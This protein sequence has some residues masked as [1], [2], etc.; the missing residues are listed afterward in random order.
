MK[1][2]NFWVTLFMVWCLGTFAQ[3]QTHTDC[4]AP[5][6]S[7]I[8]VNVGLVDNT[9]ATP[10]PFVSGT[11]V[12][13][14]LATTDSIVRSILF[15]E[16][17][18]FSV[19]SCDVA[20]NNDTRLVLL[21]A[22]DGDCSRL[23]LVASSDNDCG[24]SAF[25]NDVKVDADSSYILVW[26]N[27]SGAALDFDWHYE[28]VD[29]T[30]Y[31]NNRPAT[32]GICNAA[33]LGMD[34]DSADQSNEY[35]SIEVLKDEFLVATRS[36]NAN[37]WYGWQV[38]TNVAN[39][40]WYKFVA[41][42][43]GAAEI[44]VETNEFNVQFNLFASNGY[45][46]TSDVT[47]LSLMRSIDK[48]DAAGNEVHREYC[49]TPG[50]VYYIQVD[51]FGIESG[52]FDILV[53]ELNLWRDLEIV[54]DIDTLDNV[55][56]CDDNEYYEVSFELVNANGDSLK[57]LADMMHADFDDTVY[58]Y[59]K[60]LKIQ[61]AKDAA[62][63][64]SYTGTTSY[65]STFGL[66]SY[67]FSITDTCGNV[68]TKS[69]VLE[70]DTSV[71]PLTTAL[72]V[73]NDPFCVGTNSGRVRLN[74]SGGYQWI[75]RFERENGVTMG[76]GDFPGNNYYQIVYRYNSD[77]DAA[78]NTTIGGMPFPYDV[79]V[80]DTTELHTLDAGTYSLFVIDACQQATEVTVDTFRLR[81]PDFAVVEAH[82]VEEVDP[83]CPESNTGIMEVRATGGQG[84]PLRYNWYQAYNGGVA[85]EVGDDTTGASWWMLHA[86]TV[87]RLE[88]ES[89]GVYRVIVDDRCANSPSINQDTAWFNLEDP[90]NDTLEVTLTTTAP[91][92]Y[93][94]ADGTAN[95]TIVGGN[96]M[97]YIIRWWVDGYAYPAW[98][99]VPNP[100]NIPQGK[101]SISVQDR[102]DTLSMINIYNWD[103]TYHN[104]APIPNNDVCNAIAITE[105]DTL[106]TYT[107]RGAT[108]Q[109]GEENL[110]IPQ[111]IGDNSFNGWDEN[112]IDKSVWFSFVAPNSG[113]VAIDVWHCK[114][115]NNELNFDPQ[116]AVFS[117]DCNDLNS[118]SL[119]G[120]ND[121]GYNR[122]GNVINDPRLELFCLNPGQTYYVLVDG[123][124]DNGSIGSEEGV[125]TIAIENVDIEAINFNLNLIEAQCNA[126][127]RATFNGN[128]VGGVYLNHPNLQD[129]EYLYTVSVDGPDRDTT[130]E[131]VTANGTN[132][133]GTPTISNF[134]TD[135]ITGEYTVTITDFCGTQRSR[136]IV[137]DPFVFKPFEIDTTVTNI[138]CPDGDDGA[139]LVVVKEGGSPGINTYE[140][141][142]EMN[143]MVFPGMAFYP[144]G[145]NHDSILFFGFEEGLYQINVTDQCNNVK[146]INVEFEDP[147]LDTIDAQFAVIAPSCPQTEDGQIVMAL[148]SGSGKAY[149]NVYRMPGR[150]LV[151]TG[152]SILVEGTDTVKGLGNTL[153]ATETYRIVYTDMCYDGVN[154]PEKYIDSVNVIVNDPNAPAVT[155]V[156]DTIIYPT[157]GNA[158]GEV[159]F[160]ITGGYPGYDVQV[161]TRTTANGQFDIQVPFTQAG[162]VYTFTSLDSATY[163][164][165][166]HDECHNAGGSSDTEIIDLYYQP[167]N[168][169]ACNAIELMDNIMV[170]G[171]N[172]RADD[173]NEG[174]T[175]LNGACDV[176]WCLDNGD[177]A[178]GVWYTYTV[179]ASDHGVRVTVDVQATQ[180]DDFQLAVFSTD[181][182]N[183]ANAFTLLA[184]NDQREPNNDDPKV[185]VGCQPEGT[186]L[187]IL[188][189][190]WK[191]EQGEFEIFAKSEDVDDLTIL[192]NVVKPTNENAADG[193][194]FIT[195]MGGVPPY[196]YEWADTPLETGRVR[197]NLTAGE[198]TVT[199]TDRCG[200]VESFT[201]D[202]GQAGVTNDKPCNATSLLLDGIFRQF[203]NVGSTLDQGEEAIQPDLSTD[204]FAQDTTWCKK[205]VNDN[206]AL[207][208]TVWFSFVAPES[209]SVR[210]DLTN[211][212]GNE[213]DVQVAVYEAQ[214][215]GNYTTYTLVGANDDAR[216]GGLGSLLDL[217]GLNQC[218]EYLVMVDSYNAQKG[219]FGIAVSDLNPTGINVGQDTITNVCNTEITFDLLS[220]LATGAEADGVFEDTDGTGALSGS[221][222]TV[223]NLA[224]GTYNFDYVKNAVYCTNEK[225]E[226]TVTF[227]LVVEN[228]VGI[229]R[230]AAATEFF[231]IYPNPNSG[232]FNLMNVGEAKSVNVV[233]T[234][235]AGKAVY[236]NQYELNKNEAANV[237]LGSVATG[238]YTVKVITGNNTPEVHRIV[239]E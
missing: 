196:T 156:V 227:T 212:L 71:A 209:G 174:F 104:L 140:V 45:A 50:E 197:R 192:N 170:E 234:D 70:A 99:D 226:K 221:V 231:S 149:V 194:I 207:D 124:K 127:A 237:D 189:D 134:M 65:S 89:A 211:N 146:Q 223:E 160:H 165:S 16:D 173:I 53:S 171:T 185:V 81:D 142:D 33:W 164:I 66:G 154:H 144:T 110:V 158:D 101:V 180:G 38:D 141:Y 78:F 132:I 55:Y 21:K 199:V 225:R 86:D 7:A 118:L 79:L 18:Y 219:N 95:L 224:P 40:V 130:M 153:T 76:E 37:T 190:G 133:G 186:V 64:T 179:P 117:G 15:E 129:N 166:V 187:Y 136:T 36:F 204:C 178:A 74:I 137:V 84:Y 168:N 1:Y 200:D 233:V 169:L 44:L 161:R 230:E 216:S 5:T 114:L 47:E 83:I 28:F 107:N 98:N 9:V 62:A 61:I 193:E 17:G 35:A 205:G 235:L 56:H 102:C 29:D 139:V 126:P 176:A 87:Q 145:A 215:C 188:V 201:L 75:Y 72:E 157:F 236:T 58:D 238:V 105:N 103:T 120:A 115:Y 27:K 94:A 85:L 229:S 217:T 198:Y 93:A 42:A 122:T 128:I 2:L 159:T 31:N 183:N 206:T 100:T 68:F 25:V 88:M 34:V 59:A 177:V 195:A 8:N 155:I 123:F 6:A 125:F 150:T 54:M 213:I 119:I 167:S 14:G 39:T 10:M 13:I 116:V 20:E 19:S 3:A 239:V 182:C 218:F 184:A 4:F 73:V 52:E 202:L 175:G 26:D 91:T 90:I 152:G 57:Y 43:T 67:V 135:L 147:T 228:C 162:G 148:T 82:F 12:V 63:A 214:L 92:S 49:L 220:I 208:G 151:N 111:T 143:N 113:A 191:D 138:T 77:E 112:S 69:F 30:L 108:V 109:T 46:C 96:T 163:R 32:D 172:V 11:N 60:S 22:V 23:K 51:G 131:D 97:D 232:V 48:N 80:S 121:D 41:P 222:V 210:V 181:D 203:S 24:M 106:T